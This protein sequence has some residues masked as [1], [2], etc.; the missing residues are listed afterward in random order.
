MTFTTSPSAEAFQR[1]ETMIFDEQ[2][3][4]KILV[5]IWVSSEEEVGS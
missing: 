5:K 2:Q 1:A 3:T 4:K